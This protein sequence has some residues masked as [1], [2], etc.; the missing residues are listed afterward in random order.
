MHPL[1]VATTHTQVFDI[2]SAMLPPSPAAASSLQG[3]G[4][5]ENVLDAESRG[6]PRKSVQ[7]AAVC[8]TSVHPKIETHECVCVLVVS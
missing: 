1:A 8:S 3:S 6:E 5:V 7:P 2:L 4:T